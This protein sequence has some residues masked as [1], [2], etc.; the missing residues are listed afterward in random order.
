MRKIGF[1]LLVTLLIGVFGYFTTNE[2]VSIIVRQKHILSYVVH[3]YLQDLNFYWKDKEGE[4]YSTFEKLQSSF[5]EDEK[6]L[7]FATNGGMF[8]KD[9]SPQ[10]LYIENGVTLIPI[11]LKKKGYGNFYLQPNGVFSLTNEGVPTICTSDQF[12]DNDNVKY[13]TQS[14]P[15]LVIDGF[16]HPEFTKGSSNV[17]IRNGVGI[18]PSGNLLFAMSKEKMNFYDF[19]AFFKSN[20]CLNALYLDGFVS[21]AYFP[22]GKWDKIE[23]GPF[24]V[25]IGVTE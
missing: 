6:E 20:G 22:A 21:R 13:A 11:D 4:N 10:G 14:G 24:G 18:L 5:A 9:F 15:M 7:V 8:K 16:I 1:L 23:G 2:P 3:P 19:A 12:Q 25:I 17:H